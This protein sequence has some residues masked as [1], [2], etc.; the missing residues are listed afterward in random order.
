LNLVAKP[1]LCASM[2]GLLI[3]ALCAAAGCS[4]GNYAY[5]FDLLEP[6]ARNLTR[7]GERD[8]LEDGDIRAEWL[9]DPTSFQAMVVHLTNK[10]E[11]PL[12]LAWNDLILIGPDGTEAPLRA[13]GRVEPVESGA[14]V[15]VRLVPF[16]LPGFGPGAPA[17]DGSRFEVVVPVLVRGMQRAYRYHFVTH[18]VRL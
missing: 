10:T 14:T 18:V 11:V 4:A 17:Y 8:I 12:Q 1:V 5:S 2:R 16:T 3:V 7:P 9:L 15:V 13:E 6:G